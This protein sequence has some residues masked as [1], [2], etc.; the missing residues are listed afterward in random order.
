MGSGG[1]ERR[2]R[3]LKVMKGDEKGRTRASRL[4]SSFYSII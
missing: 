4:A 3:Q 2:E 1:K